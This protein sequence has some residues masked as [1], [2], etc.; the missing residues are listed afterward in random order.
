MANIPGDHRIQKRRRGEVA[1]PANTLDGLVAKRANDVGARDSLYKR[2]LT[3]AETIEAPTDDQEMKN[4]LFRIEIDPDVSTRTCSICGYRGKWISEM[5]RHKR[6]HTN[7]R[8]FRCKYCSRTSKWKADLVRHVAKTHGIRVVSKYS[9]SKTFHSNNSALNMINCISESNEKRRN[10]IEIL[11]DDKNT[12]VRYNTPKMLR[13]PITYRCVICLIEQESL[14][15][16]MSH[17]KNVHDALPY[18]CHSCSSSF[19]DANTAMKHFTEKTTCKRTDLKINIVPLY[20]T[21]NNF[22]LKPSFAFLD[23]ATKRTAQELFSKSSVI[24]SSA[25]S[26]KNAT[27]NAIFPA[28]STVNYEIKQPNVYHN[29]RNEKMCVMEGHMRMQKTNPSHPMQP[30]DEIF[31]HSAESRMKVIVDGIATTEQALTVSRYYN[32]G[33]VL[34]VLKQQAA[35]DSLFSSQALSMPALLS[36][37]ASHPIQTIIHPTVVHYHLITIFF[38]QVNKAIQYYSQRNNVLFSSN[39]AAKIKIQR[40][41]DFPELPENKTNDTGIAHDRNITGKEEDDFIDVV[42]FDD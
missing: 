21:R 36:E 10:N 35:F 32:F 27:E 22:N 37:R 24:T 42:Q 28:L 13:L 30:I 14:L 41:G 7:E 15:V 17:L 20:T 16:L 1:N 18:E 4:F 29:N 2:Y 5:I 39:P 23:E 38:V 19:M 12:A 33:T 40:L 3:E 11:T 9:R 6:V 34:S 8:P 25:I 31:T 26:I